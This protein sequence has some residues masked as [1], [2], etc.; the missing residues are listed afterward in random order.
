MKW[1]NRPKKSAHLTVLHIDDSKWVR[2]PV[3]ILLRREFGMRVLEAEDGIKGLAIA[4][5]ELPDIILLDVMMPGLDGFDTLQKL[6][7]NP[8]TKRAFVLMCTAR[9]NAREVNIALS[10]GAYGYL[11]KPIEEERLVASVG[12]IVRQ[13]QEK[14]QPGGSVIDYA[15]QLPRPEAEALIPAN[16]VELYASPGPTPVDWNP[17]RYCPRCRHGLSMIEQYHAWYCYPCQMYP[18]FEKQ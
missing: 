13:I 2:I 10:L 12:K 16:R 6:K 17:P 1:F 3:S 14:Q 11:T 5:Q 9:D 4:Q 8:R 15:E 7:E 18:D